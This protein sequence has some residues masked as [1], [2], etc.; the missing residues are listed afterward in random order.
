MDP[1]LPLAELFRRNG[2]YS[3]GIAHLAVSRPLK[4]RVVSKGLHEEVITYRWGQFY[5]AEKSP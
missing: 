3:G 1:L 4:D 5:S 2:D